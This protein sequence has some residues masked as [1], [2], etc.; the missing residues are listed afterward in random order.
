MSS[1]DRPE[2]E[3]DDGVETKP[4]CVALVPVIPSAQWSH[5]PGRRW[6]PNSIFIT[7]LIAT[8]EPAPQTRG[9][10]RATLV[11]AQSAYNA[12]QSLA[13]GAGSRTRQII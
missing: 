8:A 7:Q 10:R 1:T 12:R 4:P 6:P 11:D 13:R 3:V 2:P 5:G 9:L